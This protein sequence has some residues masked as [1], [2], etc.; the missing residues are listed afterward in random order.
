MSAGNLSFSSPILFQRDVFKIQDKD[1][2]E[3]QKIRIGHHNEKFGCAWLLDKVR[4]HLR[5][6][7]SGMT[8][9]AIDRFSFNGI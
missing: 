7:D 1:I 4:G 3:I 5:V 8:S 2:G 9:L 6:P